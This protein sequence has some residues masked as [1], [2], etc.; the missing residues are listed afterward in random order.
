MASETIVA[1]FSDRPQA[2]AAM[3]DLVAAGV[4]EDAIAH[5]TRDTAGDRPGLDTQHRHHSGF[6]GWLSGPETNQGIRDAYNRSIESG[7]TIVTVVSDDADRIQQI[8][9][10]HNP[11]PEL[12]PS[13]TPL[14]GT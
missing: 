1:V 6:W 11:L 9:D 13:D 4:P 8:L 3:S 14:A 10:R 5:C 12:P 7:H 2:E